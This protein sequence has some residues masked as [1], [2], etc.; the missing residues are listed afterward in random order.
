MRK[1]LRK[2]TERY[3]RIVVP[4]SADTKRR[5]RKIAGAR[6][7]R[8]RQKTNAVPSGVC[9]R[10]TALPKAEALKSPSAKIVCMRCTTVR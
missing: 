1:A 4:L 6:M 2:T 9:S 8:A 5:I 3:V 10:G 7:M